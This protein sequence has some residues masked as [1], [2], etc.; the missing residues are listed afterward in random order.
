MVIGAVAGAT[1]A[2]P[3][4][5]AGA[6]TGATAAPDEA[7]ATRRMPFVQGDTVR[8]LL[9]RV[10]GVGLLADLEGAY[11]QRS[12]KAIPVNLHALLVLRDLTADRPIELGDTLVVP[13]KRRNVLVE[14][15]VFR[16]GEYP[17]NPSYGVNEYLSLAGG[18]N[19]FAMPMSDVR[20]V[21]PN[22]ETQEYRREL[23]VGPGSTLVVPERNF[24]RAEI[25]QI[26]I[27]VASVVV[28]GVAVVIAARK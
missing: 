28:S 18:R 16:P 15:A 22:G 11:I 5:G 27:A 3:A 12:G 26:A 9:D 24:S 10:G 23:R 1:L 8:T 21:T 25:V 6:S 4:A 17:F 2:R 14:G 7:S 20:V 19:R 13:F